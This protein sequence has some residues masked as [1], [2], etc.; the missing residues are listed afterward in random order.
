MVSKPKTKSSIR[1]LILPPGMVE[2]L[3]ELKKNATCDWVFPSPVK[4]GEPRNT[5]SLYGRFQ[6]I[7]QRAQ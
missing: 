4:E 2:I 6:K 5:D 7:L 3:A 1:T